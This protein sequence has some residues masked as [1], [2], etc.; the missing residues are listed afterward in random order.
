MGVSCSWCDDARSAASGGVC[1]RAWGVSE[2]KGNAS[3]LEQWLR[4]GPDHCR[5]GVF[6][7]TP[8]VRLARLPCFFFC[9]SVPPPAPLCARLC[10]QDS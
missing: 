8:A 10:V 1:V 5:Q 3:Q 7:E 4:N 2:S 9:S 6:S